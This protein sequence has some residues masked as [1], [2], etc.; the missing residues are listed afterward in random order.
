MLICRSLRA[1]KRIPLERKTDRVVLVTSAFLARK[2]NWAVEEIKRLSLPGFEIII[3]PDGEKAKDWEILRRLLARFAKL[4]LTKRSLVI[5]LGGGSVSDL[6]GFAC[7][8]YKRASVSY[9]NIPTTLLA[10]VDASIGG[11]TAIDFGGYKNLVGT[12]YEPVAI[13]LVSRF[14]TSLNEEQ[15]LDGLAEI[16]KAGLVK[17]IEIINVLDFFSMTEL[18][19]EP[20]LLGNLILRAINVKKYFVAKDPMDNGVRQILNLGHTIGHA[21]ELKHGLSHGRAVLLGMMVELRIAE[22]L[23]VKTSKVSKRLGLILSRLGIDLQL[24]S[25]IDR[26]AILHDKKI[27]G[28]YIILPVVERLGKAR[29]V[30]VRLEKLMAAIK[31]CNQKQP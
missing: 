8:I 19:E 27:A 4:R 9:I 21:L 2:L 25:T 22:L 7:S 15:F 16:I 20:S 14:L 30:K 23:G 12:F 5:A 11:K 6:V 1:L 13:F 29:L 18:R 28:S 26:K 24:Q 3:I 17:D 10:Q 31:K